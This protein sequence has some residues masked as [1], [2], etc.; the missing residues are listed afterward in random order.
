[1][2]MPDLCEEAACSMISRIPNFDEAT[3]FPSHGRVIG[4]ASIS[5]FEAAK[6]SCARADVPRST[7]APGESS[8]AS[9]SRGGEANC[10]G[11]L[12]SCGEG[13]APRLCLL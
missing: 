1:M 3:R 5:I 4:D 10:V 7:K 11:V 12:H 2:E 9:S 8:A 13:E 6:G